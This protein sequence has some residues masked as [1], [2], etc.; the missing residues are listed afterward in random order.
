MNERR[1][2]L[3]PHSQIKRIVNEETNKYIGDK[4]ISE[5]EN[6][7][8]LG[9]KTC[10]Q[11]AKKIMGYKD[12]ITLKPDYLEFEVIGNQIEIGRKISLAPIKRLI[13]AEEIERVNN[14]AVR[15]IINRLV[16]LIKDITR[17]ASL[18]SDHEGMVTI[19]TRH[20]KYGRSHLSKI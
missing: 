3:I 8:I 2:N 12:K 6:L 5:I 1:Q 16:K 13:R 20:I 18:F 9:I 4:A 17:E 14:D 15:K 7:L 10:C 19:K 11:E